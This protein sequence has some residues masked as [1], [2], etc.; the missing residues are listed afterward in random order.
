MGMSGTTTRALRATVFT[1][2]CVTLS[3]STHVLLSGMPLPL[4]PLAAITAVVFVSA[5]ALVGRREQGFWRIATLL[6]P[7][8]LAADTVFTTGQRAC[9]DAVGPAHGPPP[10]PGV[11]LLCAGGGFG[12]PLARAVAGPDAAPLPA[13]LPPAAPWLLLAAHLALGLL[14]ADWLRRGE[15]ALVKLAQAAAT[16]ACRPL[17]LAATAGRGAVLARPRVLRHRTVRRLPSALF[18]L[19]HSVVRR[20]PPCPGAARL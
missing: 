12:T 8:E 19:H 16:A 13:S 1:A 17:R 14:A 3:A 5:F 4:V 15:A 7:L 2:L 9:F 20:G 11:D 18:L 6:V 10:V